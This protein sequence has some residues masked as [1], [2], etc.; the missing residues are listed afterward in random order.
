MV[1]WYD[2]ENCFRNHATGIAPVNQLLCTLHYYATEVHLAAGDFTGSKTTTYRIAA[3]ASL[4]PT[5]IK[6]PNTAVE[7]KL[8]SLDSIILV[9]FH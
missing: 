6:F 5:P 8:L 1:Q 7:I 3:I 2:N 4:Q 9:V